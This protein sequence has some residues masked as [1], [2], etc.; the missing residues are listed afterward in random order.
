MFIAIGDEIFLIEYALMRKV[1]NGESF[2]SGNDVMKG[3]LKEK[4]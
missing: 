2:R 1:S 3:R 4:R